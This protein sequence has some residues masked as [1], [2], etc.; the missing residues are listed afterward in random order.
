MVA[1]VDCNN[2]YASCQRLFEPRLRNK[3]IVVLSNNDGCI[4]A[5]SSEA[6]DLGIKMGAPAFLMEDFLLENKV[7]IYS[8]NYALYG[9]LSDRVMSTLSTFTPAMETYSI[10]EAFLDFTG[11]KYH[12]L[13]QLAFQLASTVKQNVGIPVSVGVANTKTLAK[14]ANRFAKK[15]KLVTGAYVLD[16]DWKTEQVLNFTEVQDIWGIG[17]EYAKFLKRYKFKTAMDLSKAPE[18]W[19]RENLTV[20]GHRLWKELNGTP[21]IELEEAPPPKKNVTVARSFGKLLTVKDDVAEALANYTAIAAEKL[22]KQNSCCRVINVFLQTNNFRTNDPQYFRSLNVELPV[23]T[24][25]TRELLKYTTFALNRIWRNGYRFKKTGIMLLE[26]VPADEVQLGL[27]DKEDRKRD[28]RLMKV[29]DTIN[30]KWSGK[31]L[32]TFGRQTGNR[33]WKLRQEKLSPYY[34]TRLSDVLTVNI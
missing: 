23:A 17:P 8:S 28:E 22:R 24:N 15:I 13:H 20:V 25:S 9:S 31:E 19:V 21:C 3:A 27:F 5:R 2:F 34:T 30:K 6:K 32:V 1:L 10:D 11:M 18:N 16:C 26:L 14:M 29:L 12:D 4:I 7:E 33:R